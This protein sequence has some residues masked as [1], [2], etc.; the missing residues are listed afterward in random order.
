M[1]GNEV[2]DGIHSLFELD[3]SLQ[4]QHLPQAGDGNW[5]V[6]NYNQ[7]VGKL[8]QIG[9]PQ[10]FNLKNYSLQQ[11]G[12][13]TVRG[14][15]DEALSVLH[16]QNYTQLSPAPEY[17]E[18]LP[19]NHQLSTNGFLLG[20]QS[21]GMQQN[22]PGVLCE[23]KGYDQHNLISRG[24]SIFNSHQ[25]YECCESPTLTTNSERSEIT[26][27]STDLN[28]L[29][30][31]QQ[32]LNTPQLGIQQSLPMQQSGYSDMHLLQQHLMIKQLQ[33]LQRQQQ[34]QQ[35]GDARQQNTLNQLSA[36]AKQSA[37]GQ[38]SPLINGTPVH[39]ASQMFMNIVQR[40]TSPTTPGASNRVV[41]PQDQGQAF[42]SIG[43]SSQQPDAS[44]YGTPVASARSNM[45]QYSQQGIS[46]DAVNLLTKAGG[47]AQKPTMQSSGSFL[48]D[49]YTVLPDQIHMSQGALISNPG[50]Q[51]KDIFGPASVQSI[52][53]GNMSGSFQAGNAAQINTFAKDYNGRQE[54][55]GW[56]AM[57][58]K[59]TE[60]GPS[61]GLVPLDPMEEKLLYNMDDNFWDP[62]FGR[63]NDLGAGSFSNALENSDF[64]NAFPSIQSGSW[65]A[66]MQSAVAEASSSDTGL[67]EEWSGLTFQNTEQSTDNQLSN[68]VDSDKQQAGWI[69]SNLQSASSFS[70]KPMPMFNDSG[71]SSS[72][73][74]FQQPGTQFS[75]EQGENLPLDGSHGSSEK[76]S[77]KVT[78]EWVD[79]GAQQKQ[80]FE[81]GQQVQSYVHLDNTWAGQM[82]E[83]SDSGAHQRRTISHEDF[84]QHYAKPKGSANDGCL[85]KTS[86]GG[87]EQVQSGTDNNLFNRKDSQIINNPS[88]GQQVIDNN[89]SDY[90]RHAD[91]SATN[92]SASTE[93]KQHQISNE[94]RGIASSCEGEGEIY[95]NHQKSYQRQASNESYNSKGLS[96]RDHGQVKFFGDV[97]S[98]N[99]NF[100][101]VRSPLEEV[102][103]RDDIKSV[104]PDGSKTTTQTS[105]NM[106]ELLHKVNLST[107]GGAMAHSGSTDSNALAKVPD[108]DAHM[109][110]AQLYNQ[111]SAS[112]GFSL[113]LALPS[114]RLPNSNHFLNSQG[115]PQTL[116]YLK[117]GQVNQTWAAPPYSGQSLP[118]ANELSQRVHL[119]AKSSTFGQTGVTPFSNMKGSAVAAF[120]SSLPLL[121]NQIQMQNMP[122]SPIVSQSLQATLSSATRNPPFNLATSQ[123]T[124]RQISVNHFGE[125]FPV[126]EASQVSQPSIMSGM[127]RQGEFSAMQNAWTTLPTQQ[128]LS[129]L[130]PLKDPANLPPSMDPTD[131]SI[132]STKSGYGEMRAGKERSL[133][134][135]SFEMTDSSQPASFSRGED[136]LQK[137]CLDA[138]ALPSSS[139]LSHS[140]QEV[141]VG[142]KHDNNQAS[143]TSERNFAPAAHSLKPSSSLQQNYS[144]LHQIQAMSTAETDPIKSADDTQPVVSV[145]GQQLHEQNSR[146]RNSMDSGPNSAA[147]GDNKTLT[148]F[149]GSR[150]DPSVK[151]LSQNALQNIPSHEMVRFGQNN[152]QSQSTSSSYVTNHMNHGQGN[153]HIA[154]SWFKQY[155]TFRNGQMLSMSDARITK[156][157]SGQFSLLKPTQNLH[158]HASVG[159]VDAVEAGQAAIARPSSATPLVADEHFSAPY[160]L[161]SSINNQNFV[162]TRP[163]K[164]KAMT[165][166]LL[167]WCKEVSQGSQKLQNIS[168]SEQEWAEATN[169]LCE[170]VEDEVETLDDVHPILRSKRRL[171]LTTQLMQ[172]L[173]NPAPASIL[174]ADATS[175]YDS[176][177]YFISRVALGDTCSLCCGVRDNMQLSSDNSNM[178]SEKLK[179][180]EKTGDQ[181]ILEVMEDLTDRAKKLENDFQRLDKT[182]SVLD[183]RVECQELERFSVINRFARFHIRGQ[184]D[185]SGAAS[186]SAMHKPVPQRYVTALPMPRNLPEGVQCFTL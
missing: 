42:R 1:P 78:S 70:S 22:Q 21:F 185:T 114:Q 159:Q 72:F 87:V 148:F 64:S 158:I 120:V 3:N 121:R 73:P 160:V 48:R 101:E 109:S 172:L 138:S 179:T 46:N 12:T 53:S 95:V 52:N 111:S 86:T 14:C 126:L 18:I 156:S 40:G 117:S 169:R 24:S 162:T 79:C 89:R 146:L 182:V 81:G 167:P 106:L 67:Q 171:V 83:H 77:P 65:S 91:V 62:S 134:Q 128:N 98:G 140:N 25:E 108:A 57:Q 63:R 45:N 59:T 20:C 163:K 74:G 30:G 149:T 60:I 145:V 58:Q 94:P 135:M 133:Q 75:T 5:P 50:F 124:S 27:A 164:R 104:G 41:F 2:E 19:R 76:K 69:D 61:Q 176:V 183:I 130:E 17:S 107:E 28:F 44:L 102:T 56:P 110:V 55:A 119:D 103:S 71:V 35:F 139:S 137:Q 97:S 4:G 154:P 38:F 150:E 151:T 15:G 33:D 105:Q 175:N 165:F 136:P 26:E 177:S 31:Q 115:S 174:R 168:V 141:L 143:M 13:N 181:K 39:E 125:Q 118:P 131:N 88:T 152:S 11:L 32:L 10:N 161:P 80:S 51:G 90:M 173:L 157:V 142:M 99:A 112:Q 54:P 96:G 144:L 93:Q 16:N 7:W 123:D 68:F 132:N 37:A 122:N 47:Q 100:N 6:L 66:L 113:R 147:G 186:S 34:L 49:Q 29:K 36:I 184:G 116:S 180:F 23:N 82:Y 155:G 84:G 129:I 92:E 43:L 9:A 8:R 170:K 153:L 127:S 166:E 85:L 178:I